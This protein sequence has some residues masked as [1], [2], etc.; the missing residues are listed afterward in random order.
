MELDRKI[1]LFFV[2]YGRLLFMIIASIAVLIFIIQSLNNFVKESNSNSVLTEE[3]K[4]IFEQEKEKELEKKNY[5]SKF[6][7]YCNSKEI[8]KAYDM[9]SKKC[10]EEKYSTIEDFENKYI[11]QNYNLKIDKYM[12]KKENN[13]YEVYLT[14]DMLVTGKTTSTKQTK[15]IINTIE[16]KIYLLD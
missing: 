2:T 13:L 9:L 5:I 3:E 1:K 11:K 14:E 4:N 7:D 12:I 15:M 6:I 8:E 16:D 10:K